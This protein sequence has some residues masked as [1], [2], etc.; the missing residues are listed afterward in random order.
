MAKSNMQ[1]LL[2]KAIVDGRIDM[3]FLLIECGADVNARR[4]CGH[5]PLHAAVKVRNEEIVKLLLTN[6]AKVNVR[7][8]QGCTP[9]WYAAYDHLVGITQLLIEHGA[10]LNIKGEGRSP[11]SM[12][13]QDMEDFD[14]LLTSN[15]AEEHASLDAKKAKKGS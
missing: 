4:E 12:H 9:V 14:E 5:T 15:G 7:D 3:V 13:R 6:G 10:D 8:R 2:L 11:L 1:D